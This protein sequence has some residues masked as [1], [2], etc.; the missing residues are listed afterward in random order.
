MSQAIIAVVKARRARKYVGLLLILIGIIL[1]ILGIPGILPPLSMLG[2]GPVVIK[3]LSER[4]AYLLG[5]G[6]IMILIGIFVAF[7]IKGF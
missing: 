2:V 1:V 3:G 7:G 4:S 6:V 5:S